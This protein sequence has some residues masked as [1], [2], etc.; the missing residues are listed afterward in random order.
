MVVSKITSAMPVG[1][2]G[3]IVEIEGD[4]SRGLPSLQIVGM[5]NKTI[6][7]AKERVRSAINNSGFT[8][9]NKRITINLAPAELSKDG[10]YLDLPIALSIMVLSNQ[11]AQSEVSNRWF[12]GELALD[13][14]IRPVRGIINIVELA[15]QSCASTVF[16]PFDNIVQARLIDGIEVIGVTNLKELF[17]HL[18]NEIVI[19]NNARNQ[20]ARKKI[21]DLKYSVLLDHIRGQEQAKRAMI[22]AMAGRHNI[23]ISGPPGAGKTMLAKA[24]TN[25]LSQLSDEEMVSVTKVHSIAGSTN[26]IVRQRPFRS[27]HHSASLVSM[28][29]GGTRP[30]PGEI[31]LANHGVLFLDELP[32]YSRS[33]LEALR[34]PLE[35]RQVTLSRANYKVS[36]PTD[37][38]MIATMNPCHCGFFGDPDN[39]CSCTAAQIL[40]YQKKLSG[41]LLDRIDMIIS[42]SKVPNSDLLNTKLMSNTQHISAKKSVDIAR[43]TQ[44]SRYNSS[45]IYNS[46]LSSNE[47][48]SKINLS[49]PVQGL[50]SVASDKLKLSARSYFKIIKVARTIADIEGDENIDTKHVSEAL[51]Y[52]R[53]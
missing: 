26:E 12:V 13:G 11:V 5:G 33:A 41:P 6:D 25:L 45:V 28:I 21:P 47:V 17:L 20:K 36:Y 46:N 9:P 37:F 2:G 27:P 30:N 44:F 23:L 50:L 42:V 53:R 29:G 31:S 51:Q 39:E 34:Q 15:K 8:F 49:K 16:V 4:T 10:A 43:N 7:E 22:I 19:D 52:R 32:E 24:S 40:N 1:Y 48:T 14:S 35:D 18:K 38:M 3:V